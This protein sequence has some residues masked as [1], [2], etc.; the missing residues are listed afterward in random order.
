MKPD[1]AP[2]P[3]DVA[4]HIHELLPSPDYIRS[5]EESGFGFLFYREPKASR[6][7]VCRQ[8]RGRAGWHWRGSVPAR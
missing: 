3:R 5:V 1:V 6:F 8:S 4:L 7:Q 2:N